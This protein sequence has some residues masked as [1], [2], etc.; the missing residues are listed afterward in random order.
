MNEPALTL[1]GNLTADPELRFTSSGIPVCTLTIASTPRSHDTHTNQ[2]KD[3]ETLY[4]RCTAWREL[5]EHCAD[6]L[7]KGMR[8]IA[9]GRL[10]TRVFEDRNGTR[11]SRIELSVDDIGPSMKFAT[12]RVTRTANTPHTT[13]TAQNRPAEPPADPWGTPIVPEPGTAPF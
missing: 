13:N 5:A 11:Q 9:T 8:V 7:T 6:T 2:W 4:M 12:A 10:E 3:G 1:T